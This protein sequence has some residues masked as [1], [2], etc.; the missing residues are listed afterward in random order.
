M[1]KKIADFYA[2]LNCFMK[3]GRGDL[4]GILGDTWSVHPLPGM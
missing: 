1:R 4:D 3:E 2:F